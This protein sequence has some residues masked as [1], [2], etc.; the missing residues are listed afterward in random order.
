MNGLGKKEKD[1]IAR[2][3][4]AHKAHCGAQTKTEA[5]IKKKIA[6]AE[7]TIAQL[8]LNQANLLT[9]MLKAEFDIKKLQE[10]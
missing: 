9:R 10:K 7:D 1:A 2:L 8:I 6:L 5:A 3:S 4:Q